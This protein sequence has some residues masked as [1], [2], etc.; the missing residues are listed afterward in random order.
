MSLGVVAPVMV[1]FA[2]AVVCVVAAAVVVSVVEVPCVV[3]PAAVVVDVAVV[4]AGEVGS[5]EWWSLCVPAVVT[6]SEA[7]PAFLA[8]GGGCVTRMAWMEWTKL[9]TDRSFLFLWWLPKMLV[10]QP[11]I[12]APKMATAAMSPRPSAASIKL[13][14]APPSAMSAPELAMS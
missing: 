5:A 7:A 14:S 10:S 13:T 9:A 8:V 12:L 11:N 1:V 2:V 6:L 4:S 3:V